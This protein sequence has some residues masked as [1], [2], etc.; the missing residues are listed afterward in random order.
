[1]QE[2][3]PFNKNF[4]FAKKLTNRDRYYILRKILKEMQSIVPLNGIE[5]STT[6]LVYNYFYQELIH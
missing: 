4:L 6:V 5:Y 3:Y 1:M 2:K